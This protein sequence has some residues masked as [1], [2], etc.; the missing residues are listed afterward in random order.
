MVDSSR[1]GRTASPETTPRLTPWARPIVAFVWFALLAIAAFFA[2]DSSATDAEAAAAHARLAPRLFET[3]HGCMACHNGLTTSSGENVS[4]GSSWRASM[5]ANSARDPYWQASV[6]REVLDHPQRRVEIED[7]CSTCHMPMMRYQARVEGREG[8]VFAHLPILNGDKD[9]A[10]LAAD[11]VSCTLCH[12]IVSAKLG[13]TSSFNGGFAVDELMAAGQRPIFGPYDIDDGRQRIMHSAAGYAPT[14]GDHIRSSELCATCHTLY[15]STH[16]PGG[17]EVGRLPEQVPFLEWKHSVYPERS[18]C[19][20]C[21]MPV[22]AESIAIASVLGHTRERLARHDFRGGNFFMLGMLQRYSSELGVTALPEELEAGVQRTMSI[23]E[24][25]TVRLTIDSAHASDGRLEAT[26]VLRN[27]TGHKFP[28]AYPSRRAWLRVTVRDRAG[29]VVFE[30][31]A[32]ANDG[33]IKGNDNDA[34]A[35]RFEPHYRSL[36]G[37]DQVQIYESVMYD[38]AGRVTT[39]L[40][41]AV[42]YVKD[43]RLLPEGF[44]KRTA[45]TDIA[46]HGEAAEDADFV[47]G[48]DRVA[49]S[50]DVS[51]ASGPFELVAE[52]RFQPVSFRWARNLRARQ[53][54]EITR[55]VAYYEA[56][57]SGSSVPVASATARVP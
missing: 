16:G 1:G 44:E 28:T 52:L 13:D 39:G 57:A 27:L 14:R 33:S 37:D 36:S 46:V 53:A 25:E 22:V 3:S 54:R 2:I 5:M 50:I 11:G 9:A 23:L 26:V 17:T 18:S 6:R 21:H 55:F 40:L 43:N 4:I 42:R 56:M 31:G 51:K 48:G 10:A 34:D 19:Q 15:T 49:Y 29:V 32:V 41:S 38:T 30:S 35:A 8:Q 20:S 12:Q 7:A 47:G 45:S 24:R